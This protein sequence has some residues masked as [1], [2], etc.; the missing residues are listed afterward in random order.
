MF[1][2]F[3]MLICGMALA[4]SAAFSADPP[5]HRHS[6]AVIIGNKTYQGRIPEVAFAHR[7]ADA[8]KTYLTQVLGYREGNIIDLRDATQAQLTSALGN[9]ASH[10]GELWGYVRPGVSHVTVFYSGHGVPGLQ[11]RRGYLLP[12]DANPDTPEINGFPVDLLYE[13]LGKLEAKSVTVYLDACFSGESE[14]GMLIRS[15]SP[16]FVQAS[17]P[18]ATAGM[19]VLT[20]ASAEQVASWDEENEHGLFTYHLLQALQGE[21]DKEP[22]GNGD[23]NVTVAE[24]QAYLDSEMTY[25]A[26][27]R[28]RRQQHASVQG[29]GDTLLGV[30]PEAPAQVAALTPGFQVQEMDTIMVVGEVRVN[31]RSGPGTSYEKVEALGRGT[32]V[33]VTGKVEGKDWYRIALAGGR[34]AYVFAPL[35]RDSLPTPAQ[36]AVGIAPARPKAGDSFKDCDVCPEMVIVPPGSFEMG[37]PSYEADRADNEGPLQRVTI[38]RAFAIG[39]FEL[40]KAEYAAFATTTG[41]RGGEACWTYEDG[42]GEIREGRSWRDASLRQTVRDPVVCVSPEDADVYL[43]WLSRKTGKSY[44]LASDAEWEYAAR[45]GTLTARFWGDGVDDSCTYAN[46]ADLSGKK[47]F[48][49]WDEKAA[50]CHDGFAYTSPAGTY[51]A[52]AFG[53]HDTLG[54]VWEWTADCWNDS[55]AGAPTDGSAWRSGDCEKRTYRGGAAVSYPSSARSANRGGLK[56]SHRA[57]DF[58]FRVARDLN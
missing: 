9:R 10:Q 7:D 32:E 48:T 35:L 44:R 57:Y 58:G 45:A 47:V 27:R 37:S 36:P 42:K 17:A 4:V 30:V 24:A 43:E 29:D 40:T 51:Q 22:F 31:T 16:V 14:G 33:E 6:V 15:A 5:D 49:T 46:T 8:I 39:K 3:L 54:N 21:G 25:A 53:L 52:N 38:V 20:A 1:L 26:R 50:P 19:T 56:L 13:N 12:V 55:L 23:G 34:T 18:K 11:D 28:F 41:Y 2:R